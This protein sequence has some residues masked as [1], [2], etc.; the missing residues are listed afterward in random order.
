MLLAAGY[1]PP[2]QLFVHGYLIIDQQKISKSLGNAIDPLDLIDVYG[3]D[4]STGIC[5]P[6]EFVLGSI[7]TSLATLGCKLQTAPSPIAKPPFPVAAPAR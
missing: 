6:T 2:R 4:A 5:F 7:R 3:A 1:E